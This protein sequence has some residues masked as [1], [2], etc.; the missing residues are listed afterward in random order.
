MNYIDTRSTQQRIDDAMTMH[1]Q[2]NPIMRPE[3]VEVLL[4]RDSRVAAALYETISNNEEQ[5]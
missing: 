3:D 5:K 1:C 2:R 4:D